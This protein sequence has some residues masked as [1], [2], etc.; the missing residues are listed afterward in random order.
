[1]LTALSHGGEPVSLSRTRVRG[2]AWDVI[3]SRPL[4][5]TESTPR[6]LPWFS[7]GQTPPGVNDLLER[8]RERERERESAVMN[9]S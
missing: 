2:R 4:A 9:Y 3:P 8:E 7:G 5:E 6:A 1:M